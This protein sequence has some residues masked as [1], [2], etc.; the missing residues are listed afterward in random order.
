MWRFAVN[1]QTEDEM[2]NSPQLKSHG[3]N[4]FE[5][6]NAAM[7]SL[8]KPESLNKLLYELGSRHHTYGARI[9]HFP[10]IIEAL[11]ETMSETLGSSFTLE[12]LSA[13]EKIADYVVHQMSKGME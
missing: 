11:L 10:I 7:N 4:V 9:E 3:N 1:L 13:W 6:I 5:A 2:R 12:H 8:D